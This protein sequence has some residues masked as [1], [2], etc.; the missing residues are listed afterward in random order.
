MIF[1]EAAGI[2]RFKAK[3]IE[4]LRR[5]ERV[6][7]NLLRL[8]DIVEEVESRLRSVRQQAGK[9]RRYKEYGDRLQELR[10]QV[11]LV[12]WQRLSRQLGGLEDDVRSLTDQ[13]DGT[14]AEAESLEA[15]WLVAETQLGDINEAI[16]Q[17]EARLAANRQRI[18]AA[19][20]TIEHQR[21]HSRELEEEIARHRQQLAAMSVRAGD[22]QQQLQ[23]TG[24]A[25]Q[26]ANDRHRQ[27]AR[28]GRERARHD[29]AH[30]PAGS[31]SR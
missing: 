13:R 21:A 8:S 18:T 28:A 2:S 7:Q 9:A 12:D 11:G 24:D 22:L 6:E 30:R 31:A 27:I 14:I 20:S 4:A 29:R 10:T 5:L 19:E 3:K 1:E 15:Q 25:V 17:S 26:A 16:R 23:E